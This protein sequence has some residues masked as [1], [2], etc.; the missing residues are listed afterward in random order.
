MSSS[1]TTDDKS[2][3]DANSKTDTLENGIVINSILFATK[4]ELQASIKES[5]RKTEI[6]TLSERLSSIDKMTPIPILKP[7]NWQH[8]CESIQNL[9]QLSDTSAAF[10]LEPPRNKAL[11]MWKTW[12]AHKLKETAPDV[13]TAPS[14]RPRTILTKNR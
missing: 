7:S 10:L 11:T 2:N 5:S 9:I 4:D 8:W 3:T 6:F 1:N 12:W 14:D 13:R